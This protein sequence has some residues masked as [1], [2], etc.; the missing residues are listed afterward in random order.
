MRDKD[1]SVQVRNNVCRHH[2]SI[3]PVA[4]HKEY[5]PE[6]CLRWNPRQMKAALG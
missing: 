6:R 2:S 1:A 5:N 3:T 4:T